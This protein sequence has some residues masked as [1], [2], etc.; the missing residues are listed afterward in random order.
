MRPVSWPG[1]YADASDQLVPK[2]QSDTQRGSS[3]TEPL[4]R[5]FRNGWACVRNW[6]VVHQL[7]SLNFQLISQSSRG[8]AQHFQTPPPPPLLLPHPHRVLPSCQSPSWADRPAI[9]TINPRHHAHTYVN[10]CT[11]DS[12]IDIGS[13]LLLTHVHMQVIHCTSFA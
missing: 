3:H 11:S 5:P 8:S 13:I 9:L 1:G 12:F 2:F 6:K 4:V 7:V 10:P